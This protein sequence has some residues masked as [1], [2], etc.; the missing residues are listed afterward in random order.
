MRSTPRSSLN[1]IADGPLAFVFP[2]QGSQYPGMVRLLDR[3]STR[4]RSLVGRAERVTGVP[5]TEL[6]RT[7]DAD[8]LS[9]PHVAQLTVF[10]TSSVLLEELVVRGWPPAIVA[11]HSLGEYTALAAAGVVE[12]DDALRLV[13]ARGRAMSAAAKAQPGTMAAIAGLDR[14]RLEDLCRAA[15]RGDELVTLANINSASQLVISGSAVAVAEVV[16]AARLA[17]ALRV[18]RLSVGGAYHSVLMRPA[19][20]RMRDLLAGTQMRPPRIPLVSS[21]TG[22]LV[23]EVARYRAVLENQLLLPVQWHDTVETIAGQGVCHVVEVGPGRVL[24]GLLRSSARP[25]T[26]VHAEDLVGRLRVAATA[27]PTSSEVA[28]GV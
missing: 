22:E 14:A 2:G 20:D 23:T 18:S 27:P 10:V 19:A 7:G 9:D 16:E 1:R 13:D 11:G 25:L 21:V 12:W 3:C 8:T 17:G 4:S 6:M 15:T 28:T 5:L 24:F 26:G